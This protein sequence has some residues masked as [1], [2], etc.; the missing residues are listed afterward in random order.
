MRKF[1]VSQFIV[2]LTSLTLM[3]FESF[4]SKSWY[5]HKKDKDNMIWSFDICH[6][7]NLSEAVK[8][9]YDISPYKLS[10]NCWNYHFSNVKCGDIEYIN[11]YDV[12]KRSFS[13]FGAGRKKKEDFY[14][15]KVSDLPKMTLEP[16]LTY[17]TYA[18]IL[19]E[20]SIID[21]IR[22]CFYINDLSY[23]YF[24]FKFRTGEEKFPYAEKET[25]VN[26]KQVQSVNLIHNKDFIFDDHYYV[27]INFIDIE[28]PHLRY[29]LYK[30][31]GGI[32]LLKSR[33]IVKQL[34]NDCSVPFNEIVEYWSMEWY[35]EYWGRKLGIEY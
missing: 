10:N 32:D 31:Y 21:D 16:I 11:I 6:K 7:M 22:D 35:L 3:N 1:K 5:D 12:T 4:A 8:K 26:C 33:A 13:L 18:T 29:P 23:I 15:I 14:E 24:D 17:Q 28:S 34:A 2:V 30:I 9:K 27:K 20:D 19:S 25:Y